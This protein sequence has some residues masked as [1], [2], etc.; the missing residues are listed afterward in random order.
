MVKVVRK[1]GAEVWMDQA[2]GVAEKLM[3]RCF[4]EAVQNS[5]VSF[6]FLLAY[7]RRRHSLAVLTGHN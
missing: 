3:F 6:S 5:L 4:F 2:T 7:R 1:L